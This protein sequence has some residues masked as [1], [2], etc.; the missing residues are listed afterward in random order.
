MDRDRYDSLEEVNL[1]D[2]TGRFESSAGDV[3]VDT[4]RVEWV[5]VG[6]GSKFKV[7]RT[8]ESTGKW[9]LYVNMQP[10]ASFQAHRH[11]GY[12]EFFI[13][14]GELIYDVG[15]APKGT[16]GY[17]PIFAEHFEAR[18]EVE[19]EMLFL[20]QGA[21]SYFKEDGSLDYIMNAMEF[22]KLGQSE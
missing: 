7:L 15:K 20:G 19:T 10:G 11:E 22:K 14:K 8:C 5:D 13:T 6:R 2:N 1:L 3:L 16:Y 12:G 21:V 17:E 9:A 18:C 4:E